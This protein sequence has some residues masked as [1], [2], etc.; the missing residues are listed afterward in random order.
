MNLEREKK[1]HQLLG[2]VMDLPKNE[3]IPFLQSVCDGDSELFLEVCSYLDS[4]GHALE[5]S[6]LKSPILDSLSLDI[7]QPEDLIGCRIKNYLVE[8]ILGEGGMGVVYLAKQT[9]PIKRNVA[10]KIIRHEMGGQGI[11]SRFNLERQT[12]AYLNHSYIAEIYDAGTTDDGRP[13]FVMQYVDGIPITDFSNQKRLSVRDRLNLFM[14]VCEAIQHAHQKGIIHRDIKPQN[15]LVTELNG[16]PTPKII[17]FGIAK[18]VGNQDHIAKSLVETTLLKQL[19]KTGAAIGTLGYMSPEQSMITEVDVDT[20]TDVYSLGVVLY[21]LLVNQLP[22]DVSKTENLAWDEMFRKIREQIPQKPS[23]KLRNKSQEIFISAKRKE[24]YREIKNDLDW[25]TLKALEKEKDRRYQSPNE[26]KADVARYL[27][28]QPVLA[29]RPTVQYRLKKLVAKHKWASI[30]IVCAFVMI[31]STSS[32]GLWT[33]WRSTSRA[34][35]SQ[36]FGEAAKELEHSI[37]RDFVLPIHNI[38][39]HQQSML[40]RIDQIK[41]EIPDSANPEAGNYA[42]GR[43]YLSLYDYQNALYYLDKAWGNDYESSELS[44]ALGLVNAHLY[45]DALKQAKKIPDAQIRRSEIGMAQKQYRDPAKVFLTK[46]QENRLSESLYLSAL[47]DFLEEDY[48]LASV[49]ANQA[50]QE[51]PWLY[52]AKGLEATIQ[53][54]FGVELLENKDFELANQKFELADQ[55]YNEALEVGRSDPRLHQ[56]YLQLWKEK[57]LLCNFTKMNAQSTYESA[58][59]V[60]ENALLVHPELEETYIYISR[61]HG[62]RGNY[63]MFH[64]QDPNPYF[65]K[66]I[67]YGLHSL[68]MN[69]KSELGNF[70]L[71]KTYETIANYHSRHG[72]DVESTLKKAIASFESVILNNPQSYQALV[73]LGICYWRLGGYF[74][75]HK[76]NAIPTFQK[77]IH[78]L[79]RAK[80]QKPDYHV[81]FITLAKIYK[82]LGS[83]QGV[84][85]LDQLNHFNEALTNAKKATEINPSDL[86][87]FRALGSIYS[88]MALSKIDSKTG[89]AK[90]LLQAAI[91]ALESALKLDPDP[92]TLPLNLGRCYFLL[93]YYE[94]KH[95]QSPEESLQK[96][97]V[98]FK[99]TV[100]KNQNYLLGHLFL[101]LSY[102]NLA[103]NLGL[104]HMGQDKFT[105]LSESH[106]KKALDLNPR[107]SL[108]HQYWAETLLKW[109]ELHSGDPEKQGNLFDGAEH[110]CLKALEKTPNN[111]N[112][113][114]LLGKIYLARAINLDFRRGID[115]SSG[116][117]N[118]LQVAKDLLEATPEEVDVLIL[119]G[120]LNLHKALVEFVGGIE[121]MSSLERALFYLK[122]AQIS[123]KKLPEIEILLA[124]VHLVEAW[125]RMKRQMEWSEPLTEARNLINELLES[126]PVAFES[127]ILS[128]KILYTKALESPENRIQAISIVSKGIESLEPI[129]KEGRFG[130]ESI[131]LRAY[132]I[133]LKGIFS[134]DRAAHEIQLG[135]EELKL[136][137]PNSPQFNLLTFA[138]DWL[139]AINASPEKKHLKIAKNALSDIEKILEQQPFL[140]LDCDPL[141]D[142]IKLTNNQQHLIRVGSNDE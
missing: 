37:Y 87:S 46:A 77:A 98:E 10:L 67:E 122:K 61:I 125:W 138:F 15:I 119:A 124:R 113:K 59:K 116:I 55:A 51:S 128:T 38:R 88:Q 139:E 22:I 129:P 7:E 1:V 73:E 141:L 134:N 81:A 56:E 47:L 123:M 108:S 16:E 120:N 25:I 35:A 131:V 12:L 83:T 8:S 100:Q 110:A 29:K 111:P 14:K 4:T 136:I 86:E 112:A 130:R 28:T 52:H 2:K 133:L 118:G 42:L 137:E 20:R 19:T 13:Y 60:A 31:L 101:G 72:G 82:A 80:S 109:T 85:E 104:R 57:V 106:F 96:A 76:Q 97:I 142:Y 58:L 3:R 44:A 140:V 34:A 33:Q 39:P 68:E 50:F 32:Y 54:H 24:L 92:T 66:A 78:Y 71:G 103:M 62:L 5:H 121:P 41:L 9:E 69:S 127:L 75:R 90:E 40:K 18:A 21:E 70:E 26:M 135:R 79:E 65:E 114:L 107:Y 36:A 74:L 126:N 17:D 63:A 99:K 102:S 27:S 23:S 45:Q 91:Q 30:G 84:S 43:C 105:T 115:P 49:K 132:G 6:F 89:N 11:V 117:T 93:A 53:L 95:G 94:E 64:G 48:E